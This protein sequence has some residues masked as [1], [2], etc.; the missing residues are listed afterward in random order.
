MKQHIAAFQAKH[1][2]RPYT[3]ILLSLLAMTTNAV[4]A[5]S[6]VQF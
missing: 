1:N 2:V 3:V 6:L 5:A 4:S